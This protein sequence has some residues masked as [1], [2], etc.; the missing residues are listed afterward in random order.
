MS[1]KTEDIHAELAALA[2]GTLPAQRREQL[3]ALLADSAELT[4]ELESQRRAVAIV[5]SLE[6]VEA[7]SLL[8]RSIE[9]MTTGADQPASARS[10]GAR[11]VG[12]RRRQ[13]SLQLLPRFA[14]AVALVAV[15]AVALTVALTTGGGTSAPT[16]LQASSLGLLS[17]T[18][19]APSESPHNHRLLSASAAGIHYPYWGGSLG[20]RAAGARSDRLGG[21]AVTTVFYTNSHSQ[22]IGY[23]IVSGSALPIPTASTVLHRHGVS[24]NVVSRADPTILTWREAG[25]T[26][27]LTARGVSARTLVHLAAWKRA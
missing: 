14:A 18:Q 15:A 25:H 26:C 13:R 3:L 8:H 11:S 1:H 9:T 5:H 2:D 23:S 12:T 6:S 17:A 16:V 24:F 4:A 27:I 10:I 22:W 19:A 20:W 21:H 7:P